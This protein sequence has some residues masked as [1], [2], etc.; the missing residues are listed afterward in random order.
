MK[1]INLLYLI[2]VMFYLISGLIKWDITTIFACVLSLILM[3]ITNVIGKK[4]GFGNGIKILIYIF[5]LGTEVLGE[6]YHFYVDVWWFDIVMHTYFAFIIS[7]AGLYLIRY[8]KIK[9]SIYFVILFIFSLAM[10]TESVWEIFEFSMDR[11][12]GTDMQKDTVIRNI[13][14]TYLSENIYVD[15]VIVNDIDFMNR[16]GGYLDIG[17]YDTIG[18]M[19]CTVVGSFMF[20]IIMKKR[21]NC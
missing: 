3:F 10:M 13:N 6:I 20:I 1:K 5:I 7:Y 11:V 2:V 21:L 14:S 9:G 16:Y 15:K 4:L 8:F 17:L 18:D 19:I 12:I